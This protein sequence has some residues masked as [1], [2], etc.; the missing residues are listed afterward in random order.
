MTD[1]SRSG[2]V[3]WQ[4]RP[5]AIGAKWSNDGVEA[6][7]G[8]AI[9]EWMLTHEGRSGIFV[10]PERDH[11]GATKPRRMV[12]RERNCSRRV[13]PSQ[14]R[15]GRGRGPVAQRLQRAPDAQIGDVDGGDHH[16]TVP[17][18]SSPFHTPERRAL[19]GAILSR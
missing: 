8:E 2:H 12:A 10:V 14:P 5:S 7:L 4:A 6:V 16:E 17:S 19:M 3:V 11:D 13:E 1:S 15:D 18:V 9:S